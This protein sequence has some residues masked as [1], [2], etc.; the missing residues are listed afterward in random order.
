MYAHCLLTW[1]LQDEDLDLVDEDESNLWIVTN[2]WIYVLCIFAF[3]A[4][5]DRSGILGPVRRQGILG[6][7]SVWF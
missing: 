5:L 4:I 3:F 1:H 6:L 2:M 7:G